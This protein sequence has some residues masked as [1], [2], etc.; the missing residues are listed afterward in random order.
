MHFEQ[1]NTVVVHPMILAPEG[2]LPSV[3]LTRVKAHFPETGSYFVA[4][5]KPTVSETDEMCERRHSLYILPFPW[6]K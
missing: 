6:D 5:T 4:L 3:S 2:T 1:P